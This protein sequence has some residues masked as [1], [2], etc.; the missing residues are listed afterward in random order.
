VSSNGYKFEIDVPRIMQSRTW[1]LSP[2]DLR[3][4]LLMLWTMSWM[5]RPCGSLPDDDELIAA[6]IG[7]QPTVFAAHKSYLLSGWRRCKDGRLYHRVITDIIIGMLHKRVQLTQRQR[8]FR[9]THGP[10]NPPQPIESNH[11]TRDK[12]LLTRGNRKQEQ[13]QEQEQEQGGKPSVA[14]LRSTTDSKGVVDVGSSTAKQ[15]SITKTRNSAPSATALVARAFGDAF[16]QRYGTDFPTSA[17]SNGQFRALVARIGK[18]DAPHVAAFYVKHN[19]R[20]Y[21]ER[22][23][24]PGCLLIDAEKLRTEWATG[25]EMTSTKALQIDRTQTRAS[26]FDR[27]LDPEGDR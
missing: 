14:S 1:V 19:A 22:G 9:K 10:T 15:T 5:Q 18:D 27:F 2:P 16:F 7:M 25:R 20:W 13:E 26:A 17:K 12:R 21:V 24:S 11:V 3:P 23:H 4:W 8:K 6:T